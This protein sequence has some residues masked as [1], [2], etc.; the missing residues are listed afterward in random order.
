MHD[1]SGI[2]G[3]GFL[4]WLQKSW[5]MSVVFKPASFENYMGAL[6]VVNPTPDLPRKHLRK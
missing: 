2:E 1:L 4:L 6:T 5:S 3:S